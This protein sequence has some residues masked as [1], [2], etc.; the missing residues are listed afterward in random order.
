MGSVAQPSGG[1]G[2]RRR[3][4]TQKPA[5]RGAW[6]G[7]QRLEHPTVVS[8]GMC[9]MQLLCWGASRLATSGHWACNIICV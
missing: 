2:L 1:E 4:P 8:M 9:Y 7:V 6:C 5:Q 3:R